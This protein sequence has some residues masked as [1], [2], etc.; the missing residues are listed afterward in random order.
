[1][2]S[3]R[4]FIDSLHLPTAKVNGIH[5][6]HLI[7]IHDYMNQAKVWL[8]NPCIMAVS[9]LCSAIMQMMLKVNS[10]GSVESLYP[11]LS[12]L[13]GRWFM[14]WIIEFLWY[15]IGILCSD[16]DIITWSC[17]VDPVLL[18][19]Y[20]FI[21][22]YTHINICVQENGIWWHDLLIQEIFHN[23]ALY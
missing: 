9:K 23:C 15:E 19:H 2:C 6:T 5:R 17:V 12:I 10:R 18:A 20:C 22:P 1:M 4:T 8:V 11:T 14:L 16:P 7:C 3:E 13:E 21:N